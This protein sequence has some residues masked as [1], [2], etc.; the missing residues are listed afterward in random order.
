MLIIIHP[1]EEGGDKFEKKTFHTKEQS[2]ERTPI[3]YE[4]TNNFVIS[5]KKYYKN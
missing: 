1:K 2:Q 3:S 4:G 5:L